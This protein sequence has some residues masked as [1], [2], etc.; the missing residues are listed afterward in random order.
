MNK[1]VISGYYGFAN[2]GDEAMLAAIVKALRSTENSVKLTVISGN[3]Q[4]TA[5]KY[6]VA[7]I[8]RF[9]PLEIFLSLRSCDLLLSGGGSLLQDVTSKRSLL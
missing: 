2:A 9:N 4:I 1:I 3:P 7:S 8:H 5:A 6:G